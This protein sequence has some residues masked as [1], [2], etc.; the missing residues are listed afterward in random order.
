MNEQDKQEYLEDLEY[1]DTPL[2]ELD[3]KIL[4]RLKDMADDIISEKCNTY[5]ASVGRSCNGSLY[6]IEYDGGHIN[7]RYVDRRHC[8][9]CSDDYYSEVIPAALLWDDSIL[10]KAKEEFL[11]KQRQKAIEK[12]EH[13]KRLAAQQAMAQEKRDAAEYERLRAKYEQ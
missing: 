10:A 6:S 12:Q 9:C 13:A 11:E 2:T 1:D 5:L 4:C 7:V 8:G 3:Y